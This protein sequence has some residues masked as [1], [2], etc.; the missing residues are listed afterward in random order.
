MGAVSVKVA[1]LIP[2]RPPT[3]VGQGKVCFSDFAVPCYNKLSVDKL[4]K[5]NLRQKLLSM[6]DEAPTLVWEPKALAE[7]LLKIIF[8][9]MI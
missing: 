6:K 2:R 7:N 3:L 9:L 5:E 1:I 4:E 8:F